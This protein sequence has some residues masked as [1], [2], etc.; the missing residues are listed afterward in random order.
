MTNVQE[1]FVS[2]RIQVESQKSADFIEFKSAQLQERLESMGYQTQVSCCVEEKV[3]M[4]VDI[5][6][7]RVLMNDPLRLV[8][9]KT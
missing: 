1:Q 2:A 8:D 3:E 6:L 7:D 5:G 4:N 9:I